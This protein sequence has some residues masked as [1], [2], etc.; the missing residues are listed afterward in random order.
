MKAVGRL[1]PVT[2]SVNVGHS[3]LS[4]LHTCQSTIFNLFTSAPQED[5]LPIEI[6]ISVPST[7]SSN[8]LMQETLRIIF[9]LKN[10]LIPSF[11]LATLKKYLFLSFVIMIL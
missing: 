6:G 5:N 1:R 7:D 4:N 8:S 9:R 11:K 3:T 2:C 10:I